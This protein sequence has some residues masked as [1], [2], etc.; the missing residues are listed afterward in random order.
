VF[1]PDREIAGLSRVVGLFSSVS[2]LYISVF[3]SKIKNTNGEMKLNVTAWPIALG[4][5]VSQSLKGRSTSSSADVCLCRGQ[6]HLH[7]TSNLNQPEV[8][9]FMNELWV[10]FPFSLLAAIGAVTLVAARR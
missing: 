1:W 7:D 8:E 9:V 3:V 6:S 10:F 4:S 2:V 5:C